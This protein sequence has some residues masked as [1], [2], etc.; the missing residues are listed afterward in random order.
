MKFC[1]RIINKKEGYESAIAPKLLFEL[2]DT[3]KKLSKAWL[4]I[5]YINKSYPKKELWLAIIIGTTSYNTAFIYHN[6]SRGKQYHCSN[7]FI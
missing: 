4:P 1:I 2:V 5:F 6:I 3:Y 7:N